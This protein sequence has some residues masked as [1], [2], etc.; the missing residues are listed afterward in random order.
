MDEKVFFFF[1]MMMKVVRV[2]SVTLFFFFL[3]S[4]FRRGVQ[5]CPHCGFATIRATGCPTMTCINCNQVWQ[6]EGDKDETT[7]EKLAY[8]YP[9]SVRSFFFLFFCVYFSYSLHPKTKNRDVATSR[10][11]HQYDRGKMDEIKNN[12]SAGGLAALVMSP[13]LLITIPTIVPALILT[14]GRKTKQGVEELIDRLN[15]SDEEEEVT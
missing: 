12:I 9:R 5:N 1:V 6:W 4:F 13:A 7:L 3:I 2:V 15:E 10:E 8:F 14:A 11:A